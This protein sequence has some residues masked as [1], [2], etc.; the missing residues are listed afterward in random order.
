MVYSVVLSKRNW[1]FATQVYCFNKLNKK[2]TVFETTCI[3]I[4]V[5]EIERG[6]ESLHKTREQ[7]RQAYAD[8]DPELSELLR[9]DAVINIGV[10]FDGT[11][12]KKRLHFPLWHWCLH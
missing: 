3:F 11:C 8:V 12:Q 6:L 2:G 7:I 9:E 10:S 5:A 4:L 1:G